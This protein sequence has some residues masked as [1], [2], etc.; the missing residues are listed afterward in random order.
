M[1]LLRGS[2]IRAWPDGEGEM[3]LFLDSLDECQLDVPK[4]ASVIAG[5]LSDWPVERLRLRM[6]CRTAYWPAS[7]AS[8]FT[9]A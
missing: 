9:L 3:F 7:F 1:K 8:A 4:I 2:D 6:A 5:E